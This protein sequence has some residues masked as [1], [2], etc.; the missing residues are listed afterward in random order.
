MLAFDNK[1]MYNVRSRNERKS[2]H[3]IITNI[4]EG[5]VPWLRENI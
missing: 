3:L 2:E 4:P 1:Y 5:T